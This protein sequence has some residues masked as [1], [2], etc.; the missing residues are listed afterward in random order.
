MEMK[1]PDHFGSNISWETHSWSR[2]G[3]AMTWLSHT[4]AQKMLQLLPTYPFS[5][6]LGESLIHGQDDRIVLS[7]QASEVQESS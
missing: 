6:L 2:P 3:M 5:S 7:P 1:Y 4:T